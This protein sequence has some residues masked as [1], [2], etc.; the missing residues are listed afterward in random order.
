MLKF[1]RLVGNPVC[2][3]SGVTERYCSVPQ[4]ESS[5]STP[6]NNCVASLCF[7]NQT[8]SPNCK[9]ALPYTGLLKFRAPSFSNLGN[10]T[11]YT[12]LEKSLMDSFKLHQLPVDSVNLSHPRKDSSTYLVLNLQVFPFGHDRFNRTGVSSIG[13]AL[14]NQTFKPP[15]Q[16]GPFFFIGDAYLNFAGSLIT[17]TELQEKLILLFLLSYCNI[18]LLPLS[19]HPDEVTGSKKSSQTGVIVG[20]VAGGS[21]LLLLLLGAGLYAH[22]QK[23]RAEKATEQNNPFGMKRL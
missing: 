23:K 13:F 2:Q 11:Y 4:T 19:T 7:A 15:P 21:V 22:R 8:S 1:C 14:S 16:F 17:D 10:N 18:S 5:Y 6:L 9:C 20:A 3:E 12:V